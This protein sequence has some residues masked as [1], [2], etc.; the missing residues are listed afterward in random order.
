[1][2]EALGAASSVIGIVGPAVRLA[3]QL[4]DDINKIVNAPELVQRLRSDLND[5]TSAI[6]SI[7]NIKQAEWKTLGDAIFTQSEEAI[8]RC[9]NACDSFRIQLFRWTRG[10]RDGKCLTWRGR[11]I[12]GF[13]K[14]RQIKAMVDHLHSCR[15]ACSA[16][17]EI[18]S[19]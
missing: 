7:G 2:A 4:A 6:E 11:V 17:V 12:I 18:A 1:M 8:Q 10:S 14:E 16:V 19:L 15:L 5:A 9:T 3:R 13:W